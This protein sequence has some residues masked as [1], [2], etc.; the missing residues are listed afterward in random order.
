MW[1]VRTKIVPVVIVALGKIEKGLDQPSVA[2]RSPVGQRAIED[3]TNE[4]CTQHC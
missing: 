1:K 3:R 4:H 2:P